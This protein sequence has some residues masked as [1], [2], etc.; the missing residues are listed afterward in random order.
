MVQGGGLALAGRPV[1]QRES[2]MVMA[3]TRLLPTGPWTGGT[4]PAPRPHVGAI[5]KGA[6][7]TWGARP[8]V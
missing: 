6:A 1:L 3:I 2:L 4:T 8:G 7:V 5:G